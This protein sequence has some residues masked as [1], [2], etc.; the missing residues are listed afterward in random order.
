MRAHLLFQFICL[1]FVNTDIGSNDT[2][3]NDK[4][5]NDTGSSDT[6]SNDKGSKARQRVKPHRVK[7]CD[8]GA[9][10]F[11]I[12]TFLLSDISCNKG[13]QKKHFVYKIS[14]FLLFG[15]S[16]DTSEFHI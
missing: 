2:G 15:S 13:T 16:C 14:T 4:G 10:F 6:G 7:K 5:S 8:N 12:L 3:S 9:N 1:S 11:F